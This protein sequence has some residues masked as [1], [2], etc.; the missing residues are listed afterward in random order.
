MS[1]SSREHLRFAAEHAGDHPARCA[2]LTVSDTRTPETDKG[3]PLI[4]RLL[5]D[6]GHQVA[7]Q[8]IVPDEP[9]AISDQ[10]QRWVADPDI[11]AII[12]TGGT[13]ISPRDSTIEIARALLTI[14]IE[15]FGELFRV[16]SFQQVK[17]AAMLSR[18]LAGLVI[19]EPEAGGDTFI[20]ALPGSVNA[21]ETAMSNLI[22]PQLPHLIWERSKRNR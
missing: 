22:L 10:L 6:S 2:V 11:R 19:R 12:T 13:G 3:G 4:A 7:G 9:A 5:S 17:A 1:E 21:I 20:F 16:L 8:A 18:A 15:G 14:E